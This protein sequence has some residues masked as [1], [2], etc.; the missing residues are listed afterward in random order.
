MMI[1]DK[2]SDPS[3]Y[4]VIASLV[5]LVLILDILRANIRIRSAKSN[6]LEALKKIVSPS[7][8]DNSHR[9]TINTPDRTDIT[10]T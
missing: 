8:E 4:L 7:F 3:G 9:G 2:R 5:M 6:K 10:H 1:L